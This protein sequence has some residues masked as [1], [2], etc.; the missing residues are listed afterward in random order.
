MLPWVPKE[1]MTWYGMLFKTNALL[2]IFEGF[3]SKGIVLP[4]EICPPEKKFKEVAVI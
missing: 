3:V 1:L 2:V 4:R